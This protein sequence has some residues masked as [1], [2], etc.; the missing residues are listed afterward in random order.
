MPRG[1]RSRSPKG[2]GSGDTVCDFDSV[3]AR[4]LVT[5]WA[6][7][8]KSACE[9]QREAALALADQKALL[10][11]LKMNQAY[12]ATSLQKLAAIGADG[13][14]EGSCKRDLVRFLGNPTMPAASIVLAPMKRLKAGGPE[15]II[16]QEFPVMD[17][18]EYFAWL[19]HDHPVAFA[20]QFMAGDP[21]GKA[22]ADFWSHVRKTGDL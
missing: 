5:Q 13:N 17:P 3:H 10:D 19:Y 8:Q 12:A 21:S 1:E 11:K 4:Y 20:K 9:V 15:K 16:M 7:G 2:S 22:I 18:H 6:W 14:N